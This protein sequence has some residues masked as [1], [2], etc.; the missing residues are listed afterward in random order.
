MCLEGLKI[1]NPLSWGGGD[2]GGGE[3]GTNGKDA[4]WYFNTAILTFTEL[5]TFIQ[6]YNDERTGGMFH[7]LTVEWNSYRT[8]VPYLGENLSVSG[9]Q[10]FQHTH[11]IQTIQKFVQGSTRESAFLSTRNRK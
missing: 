11:Q 10:R 2:G 6:Y 4:S 5:L 1:I 7:Q 3:E 9:I 8:S